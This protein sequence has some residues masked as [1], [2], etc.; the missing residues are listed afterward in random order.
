MRRQ[1]SASEYLEPYLQEFETYRVNNLFRGKSVMV[2]L[3]SALLNPT[4][5]DNSRQ[6]IGSLNLY[7]TPS[8][9]VST[10][11]SCYYGAMK[12]KQPNQY[13]QPDSVNQIQISTGAH[14]FDGSKKVTS[15][16]LFGG[17]VY[18]NKFSEKNTM[19]FFN[20]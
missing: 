14:S 10:Q 7:S 3:S 8:A 18:I 1:I 15:P 17:D 9:Q 2:K 4:Q 11:S 20:D 13:G 12:V 19:F 6:T 5:T 16:V